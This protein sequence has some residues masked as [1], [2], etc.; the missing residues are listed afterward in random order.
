LKGEVTSTSGFAGGKEGPMMGTDCV[1]VRSRVRTKAGLALASGRLKATG[2]LHP[3]KG[4]GSRYA[5]K[6]WGIGN[7]KRVMWA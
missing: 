3:R 7:G 5:A 6:L 1:R 2:K 4:S